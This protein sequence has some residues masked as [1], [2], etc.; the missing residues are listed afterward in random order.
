[1]VGL[2]LLVVDH[3]PAPPRLGDEARAGVAG[4]VHRAHR[5]R[6]IKI[7]EELMP[8]HVGD[9]SFNDLTDHG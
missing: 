5:L 6:E 4:L 3:P 2:E 8:L 1:M 7:S 9:Y